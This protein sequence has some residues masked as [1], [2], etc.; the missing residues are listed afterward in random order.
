VEQYV[1]EVQE[2]N[3]REGDREMTGEG[4]KSTKMKYV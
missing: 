1:K 2:I 4:A 3:I